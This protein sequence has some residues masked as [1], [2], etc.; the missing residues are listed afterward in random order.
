[1]GYDEEQRA[2][3]NSDDDE[4]EV[5]VEDEDE[6]DD[7]DPQAANQGDP[8]Q[9]LE[10][11][12]L[13]SWGRTP[14]DANRNNRIL[15]GMD[16]IDLRAT[17]GTLVT[18]SSEVLL[19][20]NV[21]QHLA[22]VKQQV[23]DYITDYV[24]AEAHEDMQQMMTLFIAG[25][26]LE[27]GEW[28]RASTNHLVGGELFASR[29][30]DV[31]RWSFIE[32]LNGERGAGTITYRPVEFNGGPWSGMSYIEAMIA[33]CFSSG[34][35]SALAQRRESI[36]RAIFNYASGVVSRFG[37]APLVGTVPNM[38]LLN[39][40]QDWTA[41]Y[42]ASLFGDTLQ[43]RLQNDENKSPNDRF[44]PVLEEVLRQCDIA[45]DTLL[46]TRS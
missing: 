45:M 35:Q 24:K 16:L 3:F 28:W 42:I 29:F 1:V 19:E 34:W 46:A 25:D 32:G 23:V 4:V 41:Q 33:S 5:E 2:F 44:R 37:E 31:G 10:S 39:L 17:Y 43:E 9:L 13:A 6:D 36:L 40:P 15:D 11:L 14:E 8:A 18:A 30:R 26:S 7:D 20:R 22:P 27:F 21:L 38:P 12:W